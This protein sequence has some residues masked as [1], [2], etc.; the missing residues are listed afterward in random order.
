MPRWENKQSLNLGISA[1][2]HKETMNREH[3]RLKLGQY[4]NLFVDVYSGEENDY[5]VLIGEYFTIWYLNSAGDL[6]QSEKNQK[7]YQSH[8]K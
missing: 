5:W 1:G 8:T 3:Y 4:I 2:Y 6:Y 7:V